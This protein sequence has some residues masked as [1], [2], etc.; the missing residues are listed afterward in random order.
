MKFNDAK[1]SDTVL[2]V[3]SVVYIQKK[4]KQASRGLDKYVS[5]GGESLRDVAQRYAVRL[6]SLSRLNGVT[7][8]YVTR[9]GD[10]IKLRKK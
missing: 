7:E 2:P 9:E 8:D 3:G 4:K 5:E 10:V 1:S 6:S